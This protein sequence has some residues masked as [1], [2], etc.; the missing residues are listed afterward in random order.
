MDRLL[1]KAQGKLGEAMITIAALEVAR[2]QDLQTIET[3]QQE[4]N[5][6]RSQLE[7][8]AERIENDGTG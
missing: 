6:L 7:K 8:M 5:Q 1:S 4:I 3:Q 2:E